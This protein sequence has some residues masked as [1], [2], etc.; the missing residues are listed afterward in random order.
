MFPIRFAFFLLKLFLLYYET[1]SFR[2]MAELHHFLLLQFNVDHNLLVNKYW[3][4]VLFTAFSKEII[5]TCLEIVYIV[6]LHLFNYLKVY[7]VKFISAINILWQFRGSKTKY[8]HDAFLSFF[9]FCHSSPVGCSILHQ[10]QVWNIY[11]FVLLCL[12][13]NC[14][15]EE[16][17]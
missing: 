7:I 3:V 6:N 1:K 8:C 14:W 15:M 4:P 13:I 16:T 17:K 2:Y 9:T 5:F 10:T 11:H 12:C